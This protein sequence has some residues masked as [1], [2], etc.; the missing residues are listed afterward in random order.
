MRDRPRCEVESQLLK[1]IYLAAVALFVTVAAVIDLRSWRIP[2]W[3]TVPM[4]LIGLATRL[5]VETNKLEAL[6]DSLFGFAVGFGMLF[7]LW[8][9]AGGGAGDVK[10]MGAMGVWL[11][12]T[13]IVLAFIASAFVVA[14]IEV[15]RFLL[16]ALG[17]GADKNKDKKSE[18]VP[19]RPR[20]RGP[21]LP[22]ALPMSIV[23]WVLFTVAL[24]KLTK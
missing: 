19:G 22:Y 8:L 16:R 20:R 10:L 5:I 17:M 18:N 14:V 3:L 7:V 1:T 13:T 11:G 24:V 4:A 21:S 12:P 23:C 2:N 6:K 9:I 15:F